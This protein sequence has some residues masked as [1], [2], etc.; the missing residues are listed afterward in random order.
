MNYWTIIPTE[1]HKSTLLTAEEKELYYEINNRL[2][3]GHYCTASN[4]ELAKSL[5]VSEKTVTT[6]LA[7]LKSKKFVTITQNVHKHER[8][9]YLLSKSNPPSYEE[10]NGPN[11]EYLEARKKKLEGSLKKGIV[12]GSIEFGTLIEKLKESTYLE[13]I[14]DNSTQFILNESQ[15]EFFAEFKKSFPHKKIDCQIACF[16]D[17]DYKQLIASIYDSEFLMLNNNLSLK[18]CLQHSKDIINGNYKCHKLREVEAMI[19]KTNIS[20]ERK[21]TP[22]DINSYFQDI[23]DIEV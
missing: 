7:G 18:W 8:R 23:D 21:Y 2:N 6:R 13:D 4:E 17:M 3:E 22:S 11:E 16:P 20:K 1:V 9:V 5:G 10:R 14:T 15:I 19:E 12:L